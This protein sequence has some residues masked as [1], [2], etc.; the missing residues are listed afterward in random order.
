[1]SKILYSIVIVFIIMNSY[2]ATGLI[3]DSA[4][5]S[6]GAKIAKE[7]IDDE[8]IPTLLTVDVICLLHNNIEP[9]IHGR[10]VIINNWTGETH[11]F[12]IEWT[13]ENPFDN[14]TKP[15]TINVRVREWISTTNFAQL[16]FFLSDAGSVT[17]GDGR[18]VPVTIDLPAGNH[19]GTTIIEFTNHG[20]QAS[21][22]SA[23][24]WFLDKRC[25]YLFNGEFG[26]MVLR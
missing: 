9:E 21:Q 3:E 15:V 16:L 5:F 25:S 17:C 26:N 24:A 2:I 6:D 12:K 22:I 18:Y 4:T 1:M 23:F 10:R 13:V 20:E 8:Y 7:N 14:I 19:S 11:K